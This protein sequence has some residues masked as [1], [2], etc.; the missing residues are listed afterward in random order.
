MRLS[1]AISI[2]VLFLSCHRKIDTVDSQPLNLKETSEIKRQ[3]PEDWLGYWK[4]DLHI[5]NESGKTMTV[6]MALDNALTNQDSIWTWAIIYGEDTIKGRRDYELQVVD[7]DKGHYVVDEKNSIF[8]DA[9]LLHN[10]L[11]S[12]FK[13]GES[14]LQSTYEL[15]GDDMIFSINVFPEKEIRITGDTIHMGEEIPIVYSY[16]NSVLQKARLKKIR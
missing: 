3:F 6:P 7:T 2:M 16:K 10:S 14:Y 13:V 1:I 8:L 9:F 4:G 5:Y 15:D 12:T 11:I